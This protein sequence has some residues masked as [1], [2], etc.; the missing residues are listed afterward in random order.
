MQFTSA[1]QYIGAH[2]SVCGM[3][4]CTSVRQYI[5]ASVHIQTSGHVSD[6]IRCA[7][8][9]AVQHGQDTSVLHFIG[10]HMSVSGMH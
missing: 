4:K 10:A 3:H 1:L 8:H 7:V 2:M 9:L 6:Q 5:C